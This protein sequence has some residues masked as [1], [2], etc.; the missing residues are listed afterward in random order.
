MAEILTL[1]QA[2]SLDGEDFRR[3][4][5]S[6]LLRRARARTPVPPGL[7]ELSENG[8]IG[9][10]QQQAAR[11]VGLSE[12]RYREFESGRLP[13]PE[14][15][16]LERVARVLGMREAER[17]VLYRLAARRPPPQP[18]PRPA[19][20][21]D[22]QS[23]LDDLDGI[24]A[25]VT[26]FAW[27]ILAWN[28]ALA[29]NLQDPGPLPVDERNSILWRF[30]PPADQR[31]P[32]ERENLGA[33][34]GRVRATYLTEHGHDPAIQ[35]LVERLIEIPQVDDFWQAGPLTLEPRYEPRILMPPGRAP[36]KVHVLRSVLQHDRL[37]ITQFIPD[38]GVSPR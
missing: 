20:V 21:S 9:L 14:P 28:R 7:A 31:F 29:E 4:H 22:L 12:R 26:D 6:D 33:L 38:H 17:Y 15:R 10:T 36:R 30:T 25:L 35:E 37:R 8:S 23:M 11:L 19:D 1:A 13:R 24:P 27:N 16:F 34:I 2:A 32:D 5:L 3:Y 18:R